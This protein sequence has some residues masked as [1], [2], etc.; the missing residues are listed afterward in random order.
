M[1][2]VTSTRTPSKSARVSTAAFDQTGLFATLTFLVNQDA[3]VNTVA[4]IT[5]VF[6]APVGAV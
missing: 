5:I 6:P 4:D 1:P 2:G 3:E